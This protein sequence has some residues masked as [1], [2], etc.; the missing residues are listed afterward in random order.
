MVLHLN[1]KQI[2]F[3]FVLVIVLLSL[4]SSI[5]QVDLQFLSPP[6]H[7]PEFQST[8]ARSVDTTLLRRISNRSLGLSTYIID[9]ANQE[10][11]STGGHPS[12][13]AS[14]S[15]IITAIEAETG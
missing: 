3:C 15:D 7:L 2:L 12:A 10:D 8:T 4:N 13:S 6:R 11:P 5:H 14:S 1:R 9:H